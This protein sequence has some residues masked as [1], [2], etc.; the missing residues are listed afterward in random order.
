MA[1]GKI[2]VGIQAFLPEEQD[3]LIGHLEAIQRAELKIVMDQ[4]SEVEDDYPT[5][6]FLEAQPEIILV[7]MR[8]KRSS[9]RSLN[10]LHSVLPA[11][12]LFACSDNNDPMLI[13]ETMQMG[14]REFLTNPV[15]ASNLEIAVRRYIETKERL[16]R[17]SRF[18]GKIYI[19][20]S[21]KGG[22]GATSVAVNLAA[23]LANAKEARVALIDMNSPVGDIASYMGIQPQ[24]SFSDALEATPRL[25][26]VLLD[27]YMTAG[28]GL[29]VLPGPQKLRAEQAITQGAM[30]KLLH[31]VSQ[32]FTHTFI[33]MPASL[34][35]D[36]L[37]II[38]E[39][40]EAILV[41]ITPELPSLWRTYRLM[42]HLNSLGFGKQVRLILNRASS[43]SEIDDRE[44][45]KSLSQPIYCRLPNDYRNSIQAVR[46][47]KPVVLNNHSSFASSYR[48]LVQSLAGIEAAKP[49]RRFLRFIP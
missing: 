42:T 9:I 41:V 12:W 46:K 45:A 36:I 6:R 34:D 32:A 33:D 25:D 22:A 24:F 28:H 13:I 11:A 5:Q 10:V 48:Q 31:I 19:V 29:W 39:N 35:P 23:T 40:S 30:A 37:R 27:T 17:D 47:G 7:N 38:V 21:A 26:S 3:S 8:D 18:H 2:S 4:Y 16:K 44:I 49:H 20:T 43:R 15:S 1:S 14:A